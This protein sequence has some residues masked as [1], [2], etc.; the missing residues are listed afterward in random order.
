MQVIRGG[1]NSLNNRFLPFDVLKT[2]ALLMLD[3]DVTL[4]HD[5]IVLAFRLV[6]LV[7]DPII[8]SQLVY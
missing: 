1:K 5:E 6:S 2:E 8:S 3:D 7:F 4:R